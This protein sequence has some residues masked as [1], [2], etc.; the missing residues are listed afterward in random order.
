MADERRDRPETPALRA[1]ASSSPRTHVRNQ[2][3]WD[4]VVELVQQREAD[5]GRPLRVLDLGGGSGGLAVPLA[6]LGHDV[7]VVDPSPNALAALERRAADFG[8]AHRVT[9]RQGDADS[10][11]S[12]K[13]ESVDLVC[14]HGVLEVVDD[15]AAALAQIAAVL[16]PDGHLSLLVA[17]R[18]AVVLAKAL[19][20]EL[21]QAREALTSPDGRWGKG[22]PLPRRFDVEGLVTLLDVAGFT[23][24]Q[25][26]GVRVFT[27]LVP[28]SALDSAADRAA[29]ADLERAAATHPH[30]AEALGSL[31]AG[32]HVIAQRS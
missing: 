7:V 12:E 14:C 19:A 11:V 13:G 25:V 32:I 15:P 27:D 4:A 26:H 9:G 8:V 1:T 23:P 6:E 24:L 20:G 3:V 18:L 2:G 29:V 28:P 31:G 30:Y 17:G 21:G 16:T 10:L 5:L 22:D